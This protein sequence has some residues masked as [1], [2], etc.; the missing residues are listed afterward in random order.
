MLPFRVCDCTSEDGL[1]AAKL[2]EEGKGE[3]ATE[4]FCAWPQS[5]SFEFKQ[6][7]RVERIEVTSHTFR[8]PKR[9]ELHALG[10][11]DN[12]MFLGV[13]HFDSNV[14]RSY[15]EEEHKTIAISVFAT[16][17]RIEISG[18]FRNRL[19]V[20]EQASIVKFAV[21][22]ETCPG[23]VPEAPALIPLEVEFEEV[24]EERT[25]VSFPHVPKDLKFYEVVQDI[26]GLPNEFGML[27]DVD[28][29]LLSV[30]VPMEIVEASCSPHRIAECAAKLIP[31]LDEADMRGKVFDLGIQLAKLYHERVRDDT[32]VSTKRIEEIRDEIERIESS[33][34]DGSSEE[35]IH[36]DWKTVK[37]TDDEDPMKDRLLA[38]FGEEAP[39]LEAE[40]STE[41]D[42]FCKAF[43]CSFLAEFQRAPGEAMMILEHSCKGGFEANWA[44]LCKFTLSYEDASVTMVE[45]LFKTLQRLPQSFEIQGVLGQVFATTK[46]S[47][48][49]EHVLAF[50]QF[51]TEEG[52]D[53]KPFLET[54]VQFWDDENTTIKDRFEEF[55]SLAESEREGEL[56]SPVLESF[57]QEKK[58][59]RSHTAQSFVAEEQKQ[60]VCEPSVFCEMKTRSDCAQEETSKTADEGSQIDNFDHKRIDSE[61]VDHEETK[62]AENFHQEEKDFEEEEDG[63]IAPAAVEDSKTCTIS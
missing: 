27:T 39:K 14:G 3:W 38:Y 59:T 34:Q 57:L 63:K 18:C 36:L 23:L 26:R 61:D 4:Q 20:F 17:F 15:T 46:V 31:R 50:V 5:I 40:N 32:G 58:K 24:R 25:Q 48:V 19:N 42:S 33:L 41:F 51:W 13:L 43:G 16:G 9:I 21:F 22:G 49:F 28:L 1:F 29:A 45:V 8:I 30:N 10:D 37:L 54:V 35:D 6:C 60:V 62:I 56:N 55:T 53:M 7:C 52:V 2:L 47:F 44:E 12:E 11:G